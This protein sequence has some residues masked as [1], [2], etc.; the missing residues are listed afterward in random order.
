MPGM[1]SDCSNPAGRSA[2]PCAVYAVRLPSG[3]QAGTPSHIV[4]V[5]RQVRRAAS[6]GVHR[7]D[8]I[9]AG[10]IDEKTILLPVR[11]PRWTIIAGIVLRQPEQVAAV[12][13]HDEDVI[14]PEPVGC[15]GNPAPIRRPGRRIPTP[16]RSQLRPVASVRI[17]LVDLPLAAAQGAKHD[18][19]AIRRPRYAVFP[20]IVI[21]QPRILTPIHLD[22]VDSRAA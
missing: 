8:I 13:I 15:E 17:H 12:G 18:P 9:C 3:D 20:R 2:F 22:H 7:V 21:R 1:P 16:A 5:L 14:I 6:V 19:L 4:L 10:A 11:R